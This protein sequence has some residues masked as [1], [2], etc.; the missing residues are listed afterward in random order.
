M[1]VR[2]ILWPVSAAT[3][4]PK[5]CG[6]CGSLRPVRAACTMVNACHHLP[7][8]S[9]EGYLF[10]RGLPQLPELQQRHDAFDRRCPA[11]VKAGNMARE[12]GFAGRGWRAAKTCLPQRSATKKQ[13][14]TRPATTRK[15]YASST[16]RSTPAAHS[17]ELPA[18]TV[19][20]KKITKKKQHG[21]QTEPPGGNR[22]GHWNQAVEQ[23]PAMPPK[24]G[25]ATGSVAASKAGEHR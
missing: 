7:R 4:R 18:T 5:Q 11:Y 3:F 10:A 25:D 16:A 6:N 15:K 8:G 20:P 19:S 1:S 17:A 14:A 9:H 21:R 22:F 24:S 2:G 13:T 12:M 23:H